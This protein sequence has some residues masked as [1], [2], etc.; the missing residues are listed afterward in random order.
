[1]SLRYAIIGT[2]AIGGYYGARLQQAGADVHFLLRSSYESVRDH[3]IRVES[4]DGDFELPHVNAYN[5]PVDIPPVDVAVVALKTT[6]N[7]NLPELLPS[8]K[9]GGAILC[10]QNGFGVEAAI[11]QHLNQNGLPVPAIFGGLCFICSN[12]VAPGHFC[13]LDY[14]RI[15]LGVYDQQNHRCAPTPLLEE[16]VSDFTRASVQADTTDDLPMAR[17]EKLVWNVP[18]NGLSVVLEATTAGMMADTSMRSLIITLMQEVVT[19]ADAWGETISPGTGRSLPTD[20]IDRMLTNTEAMAP[21]STSMK[22]DYDE[23]RPLEIA[24]IL[25]NPVRVAR[26]IDIETPSMVMLQLQLRFLDRRNRSS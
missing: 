1:M 20:I 3:G 10:L 26:S 25:E 14:G 17:W 16:I 5:N 6:Q 11:A 8:L 19:T 24:A 4:T 2:G 21:Y 13:H 22:I 12:Q 15:L 7:V 9:A 23:K 18:Y